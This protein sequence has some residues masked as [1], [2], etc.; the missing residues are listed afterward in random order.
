MNVIYFFRRTLHLDPDY[1]KDLLGTHIIPSFSSDP[2]IVVCLS[3]CPNE[4]LSTSAEVDAY[5][6]RTN[7]S[8]CRYDTSAYVNND[9][10]CLT[11]VTP[12]YV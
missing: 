12:Q 1:Y 9:D 10:I 2:D 3:H 7:T 5:M 11:P 4:T 6:A 8:L